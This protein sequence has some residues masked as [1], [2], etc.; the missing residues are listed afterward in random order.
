MKNAAV[1]FVISNFEHYDIGYW[2][3]AN[4]PPLE[5]GAARMLSAAAADTVGAAGRFGEVFL[6]PRLP[7]GRYV[8]W[9]CIPKLQRVLEDTLTLTD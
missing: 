9:F 8:L 2:R 6:S 7:D 3:A 1:H 5:P 4:L